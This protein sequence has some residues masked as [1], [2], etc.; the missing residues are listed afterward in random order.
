MSGRLARSNDDR[1]LMLRD[2]VD[3]ARLILLRLGFLLRDRFLRQE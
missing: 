1:E 3:K 2:F